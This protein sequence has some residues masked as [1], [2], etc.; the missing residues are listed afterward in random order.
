[1]KGDNANNE[2]E[3]EKA[4]LDQESEKRPEVPNKRPDRVAKRTAALAIDY[5]AE[6]NNEEE[7]AAAAKLDYVEPHQNDEVSDEKAGKKSRQRQPR[8]KTPKP[9]SVRSVKNKA[10]KDETESKKRATPKSA[11]RVKAEDD[12][13]DGKPA[14]KPRGRKAGSKT[15]AIKKEAADGEQSTQ[16]SR[17][18]RKP[19]PVSKSHDAAKK[20]AR[21]PS[22]TEEE[23]LARDTGKYGLI[24]DNTNPSASG[25]Y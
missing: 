11:T 25:T 10:A 21:M 18:G 15:P 20:K 7:E 1:M 8:S 19:G 23:L 17:R 12:E 3:F 5:D 2:S 13:Q 14:K 24:Q 4:V 6:M 9:S 22:M 16:K